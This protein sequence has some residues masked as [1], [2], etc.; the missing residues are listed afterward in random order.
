MPFLWPMI[1]HIS[2]FVGIEHTSQQKSIAK[3]QACKSF[4]S[5]IEF[6]FFSLT[7]YRL[8]LL[9]QYSVFR[10]TKLK[11]LGLHM[12]SIKIN[13]RIA[14]HKIEYEYKKISTNSKEMVKANKFISHFLQ[15]KIFF[16][17][18]RNKKTTTDNLRTAT[19]N[20]LDRFNF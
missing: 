11:P 12:H 13:I 16:S 6:T 19:L 14:I 20:S 10:S 2:T 8:C 9:F 7:K 4:I 15:N 18:Q 5:S 1:F 3:F 17:L